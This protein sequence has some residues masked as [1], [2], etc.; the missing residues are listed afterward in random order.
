MRETVAERIIEAARRGELHIELLVQ[1]GLRG[2]SAK[3]S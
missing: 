3:P 2:F 1:T